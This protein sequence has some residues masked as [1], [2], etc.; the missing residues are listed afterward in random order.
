MLWFLITPSLHREVKRTHICNLCSY[1]L[2]FAQPCCLW[3]RLVLKQMI[4]QTMQS[5]QATGNNALLPRCLHRYFCGLLAL[6]CQVCWKP[7]TY[8]R[9]YIFYISFTW[10]VPSKSAGSSISEAL[11]W[12]YCQLD[13]GQCVDTSDLEKRGNAEP[14]EL[15]C[16]VHTGNLDTTWNDRAASVQNSWQ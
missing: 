7:L 3:D 15:D 9:L 10:C 13:Q 1:P 6:W 16:K 4:I 12:P 5:E 11:L 2:V 8:K 14:A